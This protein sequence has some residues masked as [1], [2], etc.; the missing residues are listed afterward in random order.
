MVLFLSFLLGLACYVVIQ[1]RTMH[2]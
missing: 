2:W 1:V